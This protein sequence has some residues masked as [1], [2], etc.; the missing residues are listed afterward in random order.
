MSK[1]LQVGAWSAGILLFVFL[2]FQTMIPVPPST[3]V[4]AVTAP[5]P[6]PSHA[7]STSPKAPPP[8]PVS[9]PIPTPPAAPVVAGFSDSAIENG[10]Y[11]LP[12][13]PFLDGLAPQPIKFVSGF[14][15][16]GSGSLGTAGYYIVQI[17]HGD[18][19]GDGT[20]D[21]AVILNFYNGG[22]QQSWRLVVMLN[23]N[24]KVEFHDTDFNATAKITLQSV[25]DGAI[26]ADF[27]SPCLS[28]AKSTSSCTVGTTTTQTRA[29]V[30]AGGRLIEIQ[31]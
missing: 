6:G 12:T 30:W 14:G 17:V 7:T 27:S 20:D 5:K 10:T 15:Q 11:Q 29:F 26:T 9:K 16:V 31:I 23:K 8:V 22:P 4:A 18:I 3:Q 1:P 13:S 2:I 25:S 19:N 28:D 24:G 21:A